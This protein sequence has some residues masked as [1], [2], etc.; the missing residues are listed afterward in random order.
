MTTTTAPVP[1]TEASTGASRPSARRRAA[2]AVAAFLACAIPVT[3]TVTI[4]A[5]L[6]TGTDAD[7][8]FHQLTGQG[9]VLTALWLGAL[10][11][12][13]RAGWRGRRPSTAAGYRHLALVGAGIAASAVAAGGGARALLAVATVTG[14]ILWAALP[15]RPRLRG[16]VAVDPVL[17]AARPPRRGGPHA[18]RRRPARAPERRDHRLPLAEPPP[19]RHGLGGHHHHRAGAARGRRPGGARPPHLGGRRVHRHRG[20]RPGDRRVGHLVRRRPV[21]R[22]RLLRRAAPR[23]A[24]EPPR[25]RPPD[26]YTAAHASARR[27]PAAAPAPRGRRRPRRPGSCAG[28]ARPRPS[29]WPCWPSWPR[30]SPRSWC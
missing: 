29:C 11:P 9:L 3:F 19:V 14:A 30:S 25:N 23:R 13:V 12:L 10:L 7:H 20:C 2:V 28:A 16:T 18:V 27:R 15:L 17:T 24:P 21:P 5:M 26:A 8:R 1:S 6:V 4:T 22:A